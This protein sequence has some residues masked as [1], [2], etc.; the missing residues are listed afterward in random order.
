M[1]FVNERNELLEGAVSNILIEREGKLLTPPNS[2]GL[3][4][5]CYKQYLLDSALCQ[6]RILTLDDF[7]TADRVFI[8]NSV[9]K[10][11]LI[12]EIF[13]SKGKLVWK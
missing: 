5:G 9:K 2:L 3:L 1:I 12:E 10:E 4:N 6:E 11:I 7:K 13:D 8:C